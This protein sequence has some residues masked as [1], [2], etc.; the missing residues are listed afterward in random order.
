[1]GIR[2]HIPGPLRGLAGGRDEVTLEAPCRTVADVIAA[3]GAACPGIETRVLTEQGELRS[4]VNLFVGTESVRWTGGLATSVEPD[5][6]VW[7]L[8]AVSG[9]SD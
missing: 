8:P 3:L 2:V 4:H 5:A 9:G 6:D 7:I 1:M